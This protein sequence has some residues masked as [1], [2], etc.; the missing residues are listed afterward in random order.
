MNGAYWEAPHGP[1]RGK[2]KAGRFVWMERA[3]LH[4]M[5][6]RQHAATAMDR[7]GWTTVLVLADV[8]LSILSVIIYVISTYGVALEVSHCGCGHFYALSMPCRLHAAASS[9]SQPPMICLF[10]LC[11]P[12]LP[13]QLPKIDF[14]R[15]AHQL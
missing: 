7:S 14:P 9:P 11:K 15:H 3:Q 1:Q 13:L 10:Y 2:K 4:S 6:L 12:R 8:G 5:Q